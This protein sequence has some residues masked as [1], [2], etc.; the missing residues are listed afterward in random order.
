MTNPDRTVFE[1]VESD[2]GLYY[3]ETNKATDVT[4]LVNTVANN[5]VS[6]TNDDYSCV[7]Q[8]REIQINIGW[9]SMKDFICII[10][11]NQLPNC[12]IT[13]ADILTAEHIF[14]LDVGSL[15]GKTV[16][17]KPCFTKSD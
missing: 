4:V 5:K 14:G 16:R 8:A 10:T 2:G 11:S 12:P 6:Y 13:K 9:P 15:K 1:F 7:V 17:G 3:L